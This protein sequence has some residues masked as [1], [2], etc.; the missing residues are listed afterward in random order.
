MK[1]FLINTSFGAGLLIWVALVVAFCLLIYLSFHYLIRAYLKDKHKNVGEFLFRFSAALLAFILSITF[2]NQRVNYFKLQSSIEEEASKLVDVHLDLKL[3]DTEASQ[4]IQAK[5]RNYILLIAQ[6]GW[7]S[8]QDNPFMSEPVV[9][10]REIYEDVNHLETNTKLQE[11]LKQKLINNMDHALN[12]LQSKIYS[13]GSES[14]HLIYT[15]IFGLVVLMLLFVV[16]PPDLLTV[17]FLSLYVAFIAVVL[18]FIFMMGN[19]L[20]GPL[21]LEPGPFLLLKETIETNF[22]H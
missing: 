14:N 18:Y 16:H 21:Q 15:S 12:A 1:D 4:V 3:F 6:E 8:I 19:P 7:V 11:R 9:M 20:K 22:Q 13:S 17:G 2:A 5:V 10:I